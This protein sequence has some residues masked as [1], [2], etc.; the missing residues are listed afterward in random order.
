MS[1]ELG[2]IAIVAMILFA[3]A[4][5]LMV[6]IALQPSKGMFHRMTKFL[7]NKFSIG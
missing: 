7:L 1:I 2:G 4:V 3:I 5:G 6:V